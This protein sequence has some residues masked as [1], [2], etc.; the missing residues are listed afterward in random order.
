MV[1]A[2]KKYNR[3]IMFSPLGT[4][5]KEVYFDSKGRLKTK[6]VQFKPRRK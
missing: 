4:I 1:K 2:R 6:T 5:A 3:K